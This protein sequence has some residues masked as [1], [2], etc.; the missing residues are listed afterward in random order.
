[1]SAPTPGPWEAEQQRSRAWGGSYI[2]RAR[3]VAI[4]ACAMSQDD[5][6]LVAAAPKMGALLLSAHQHV[7][8]GGPTRAEVEEVLREAGLIQ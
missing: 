2:V 7:S 6:R 5:A 3:G 8:H 1:M 4:A